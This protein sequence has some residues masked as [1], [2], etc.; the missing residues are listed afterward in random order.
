MLELP[1]LIL[2]G[3]LKVH[4]KALDGMAAH[5]GFHGIPQVISGPLHLGSYMLDLVF[6]LDQ[7][8]VY[9]NTG[10]LLGKGHLL[11]LHPDTN[12]PWR[13]FEAIWQTVQL[14]P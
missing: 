4:D 1:R 6:C 5:R 11:G 2:L 13:I 8:M 9:G 10:P 12:G 7:C 14:N 3:D